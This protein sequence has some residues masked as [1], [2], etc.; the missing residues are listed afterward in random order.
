MAP[1]VAIGASLLPSLID[2]IAGDKAGRVAGAVADTV[3]QVAGTDDPVGAAAALADP[4]KAAELRVR[5]AEIALQSKQAELADVAN[6]R[7]MANATPLIAK[8]QVALA[9]FIMAMFFA[10]LLLMATRGVPQGAETLFNVLLGALIAAQTA[11][12]S[13]FFGNSTSGHSA[14]NALASLAG[15]GGSQPSAIATTAP[16]TVNNPPSPSAAGSTADDYNAA[17]LR[18]VQ[19]R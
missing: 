7:A 14:N 1:L 3:R 4:A 12:I 5:L 16:V 8:T 9:G 18:R 15:R 2:L 11:V 13:F 6:A 17:E 19:G 10:V